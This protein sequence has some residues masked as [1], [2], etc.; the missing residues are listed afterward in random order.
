M[1]LKKTVQSLY[2]FIVCIVF[3]DWYV[4]NI[5]QPKFLP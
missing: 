2:K 3:N 5:L 4:N 1:F